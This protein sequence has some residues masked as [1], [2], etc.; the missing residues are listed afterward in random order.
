MLR[1]DP[2]FDAGTAG[3]RV[4]LH[5]AAHH[6]FMAALLYFI[7]VYPV[8]N[9][10]RQVEEYRDE[11][12]A[13]T[14]APPWFMELNG[15]RLSELLSELFASFVCGRDLNQAVTSISIMAD[16]GFLYTLDTLGE[17]TLSEE[18]AEMYLEKQLE[19]VDALSAAGLP[20][21]ITVK[22]T[23]LY[24]QIGPL[25]F[26]Q[27]VDVLVSRLKRILKAVKDADG[28]LH[29]DMEQRV[30][31]NITISAFKQLVSE[32]SYDQLGIAI[33]SYLKETK[34]DLRDLTAFA[35]QGNHRFTVR[36]VK[37][38][39]YE[40]ERIFAQENGWPSPVFEEKYMTDA[41]YEENLAI[42][43]ENSDLIRVA[44][45]THNM[46]TA[47]EANRLASEAGL[48]THE[49]EIQMLNGMATGMAE[50]LV[51]MGITVRLYAPYGPMVPGM[52]YL[53]RRLV[54]NTAT[55]GMVRLQFIQAAA[56]ED[57]FAAPTG[58]SSRLLFHP[59]G[60]YFINHPPADF[61]LESVRSSFSRSVK[62]AGSVM[63]SVGERIQDISKNQISNRLS[64]AINDIEEVA[65]AWKSSSNAPRR[66]EI[67]RR[68]ASIMSRRIY[69]LAAVQ[70]LE[71]GKQW[72]QAY[73]D[74][75]EAIDF[76]NYYAGESERLF[77]HR[78]LSGIAGERNTLSY[79]PRGIVGVIAPWN[80]PLAISTGMTS[81][82]LVT[83]NGVLYKPAEESAVTGRLM[84][85]ILIEA[86]VPE[87]ILHFFSGEGE[88]V[89]AALVSDL[90]VNCIAF[91]GSKEVG[92]GIIETLSRQQPQPPHVRSSVTEMGGKNGIIIDA[93][94]DLDV[95]VEAVLQSAFAFQG[96]K[97]SA[98]SRAIVHESLYHEFLNRLVAAADSLIMG[99]AEDPGTYL[100]PPVSSEAERKIAEYI[101]IGREEG[102]EMLVKD[103]L[104]I[105]A[106][107]RTEHRLAREE[108]FGPVLAVM[109]TDTLR[110]GIEMAN[111]VDF[112]LTGGIVSRNRG[113]ID[114][115]CE[116]LEAGNIYV[117][118]SITGALVG[119]QPFGGFK[120][121]G[122]GTK[123]GGQEYLFNFVHPVAVSENMLRRG[124]SPDFRG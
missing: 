86:G 50:A 91:T 1:K 122:Q 38:A 80:F 71:V 9:G 99:P 10:V 54:E 111:S 28:F 96:Q 103:N 107:I 81:A 16:R 101:A 73:N 76:L 124:F 77:A 35:R 82:A 6:Q 90:R 123:A 43:F 84:Y 58:S 31:K 41:A 5:A 115:V 118:R 20:V 95:A 85:E 119:R 62:N 65:P 66:A 68:G 18:E 36:L 19:A 116:N 117:N 49:Y 33:Q 97:C 34:A 59:D 30:Y 25:N 24:S 21:H 60:Q 72:D 46:R 61:S 29:V 39:Y 92:M 56:P 45:A 79:R 22:P 11:Y 83:G 104:A 67:L 7:D 78:S 110:R 13:G 108:V 121:S 53:V 57:I 113:H 87:E 8:L 88:V 114:L 75:C 44:A 100:G 69:E 14:D 55:D 40:Y 64:K 120:L 52:A 2:L 12:F 4:L 106:D 15:S 27:S 32:S 109:K 26:Q 37:G 112:G 94:A 48:S 98:A 17:A 93:D 105:F 51:A 70:V 42:L 102:R 74:V 89:G 63:K 3:G 23:S 47:A